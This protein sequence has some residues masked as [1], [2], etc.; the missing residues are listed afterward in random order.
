MRPFWCKIQVLIRQHGGEPGN[1]HDLV[2]LA[3]H[4]TQLSGVTIDLTTLKKL[5]SGREAVQARYGQGRA[6]SP[7][8]IIGNYR[9][10]L[11]LTANLTKAL[12]RKIVMNNARFLVRSPVEPE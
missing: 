3:E 8:E 6:R 4:A 1:I 11:L 12:K 10:A 2:K 7:Q 5:P 9:I